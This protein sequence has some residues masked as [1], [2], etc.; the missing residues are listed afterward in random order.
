LPR[1]SPRL[2][3]E[4]SPLAPEAGAG[5]ATSR[6]PGPPE[7]I[8]VLPAALG[9]YACAAGAALRGREAACEALRAREAHRRMSLGDRI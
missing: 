4:L 5:R 7:R 2:S 9:P 3:R 1:L 8:R 6:L